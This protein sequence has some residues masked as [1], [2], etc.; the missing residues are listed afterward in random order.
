MNAM[1]QPRGESDQTYGRSHKIKLDQDRRVDLEH[2][3]IRALEKLSQIQPD[4]ERL[5][6]SFPDSLSVNKLDTTKRGGRVVESTIYGT[7]NTLRANVFGW[8]SVDK[9]N[10]TFYD[11]PAI[12]SALSEA[13][14][15]IPSE[16]LDSPLIDASYL[17]QI[18][19]SLETS[20]PVENITKVVSYGDC[21]LQIGNEYFNETRRRLQVSVKAGQLAAILV[22]ATTSFEMPNGTVEQKFQRLAT[23]GDAGMAE[24]S[25]SSG[26][27]VEGF[28]DTDDTDSVHKITRKI[29]DKIVEEKLNKEG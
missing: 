24:I 1:E 23:R 20:Q 7:K 3:V 27:P 12:V 13:S 4:E 21:Q 22:E 10:K 25:Y 17:N 28:K 15:G 9:N 29:I 6:V 8:N 2:S 19:E 11:H 26:S 18:A 16:I 5:I 14:N